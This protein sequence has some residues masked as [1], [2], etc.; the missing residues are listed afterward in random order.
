[1]T[2]RLRLPEPARSLHRAH[3]TDI[4]GIIEDSMSE[5][6][7]NVADDFPKAPIWSFGG[8]TIL[9]ARWNHRRSQDLDVQIDE[10]IDVSMLAA[11]LYESF[12]GTGEAEVALLSTN[13]VAMR[14]GQG[15]IDVMSKAPKIATGHRTGIVEQLHAGILPSAEILRGKLQGRALRA[16]SRDVLDL[17]VAQEVEPAALETAVN[18]V[19]ETDVPALLEAIRDQLDPEE[20][21]ER[22]ARALAHDEWRP[23]I[24]DS[25]EAACA[26]IEAAQYVCAMTVSEPDC[27]P[28]I[29]CMRRD[30]AGTVVPYYDARRAL[31]DRGMGTHPI[32]HALAARG[33]QAEEGPKTNT[34][35]AIEPLWG[36]P[37]VHLVERVLA[38]NPLPAIP[39]SPPLAGTATFA[40]TLS[41]IDKGEQAEIKWKVHP[42]GEV[43]LRVRFDERE[44]W[45]HL[46]RGRD[47][48]SMNQ[49]LV[50]SGI[51]V[52]ETTGIAV[53]SER[54]RQ[55][56]ALNEVFR[57]GV[58]RW[59]AIYQ[60]RER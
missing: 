26:A 47:G 6:V 34:Q 15:F 2:E 43:D 7:T 40:E 35:R 30:G 9:A 4:A 19:P 38:A 23:L 28:A 14:F 52:E 53:P 17:A 25:R 36:D 49:Q 29:V 59:M 31:I 5:D 41:R 24:P 39:A 56:E 46:A 1:M 48:S 22:S 10:E 44:G 11:K 32:M 21:A 54:H 58:E 27:L 60:A 42:S 20:P 18:A 3:W 45:L 16:L 51:P 12:T 33:Q 57:L 8:G 13:L 50:N 37:E 55:I